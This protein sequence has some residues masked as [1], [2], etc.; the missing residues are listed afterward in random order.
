M[1]DPSSTTFGFYILARKCYKRLQLYLLQSLPKELFSSGKVHKRI[2][3]NSDTGE[4]HYFCSVQDVHTLRIWEKVVLSKFD[5][6]ATA[7]SHGVRPGI[8]R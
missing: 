8:K 2:Y 4:I 6:L 7:A 1:W 3:M 5:L